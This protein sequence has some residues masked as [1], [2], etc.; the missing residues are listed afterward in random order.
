MGRAPPDPSSGPSRTGGGVTRLDRAAV[1]VFLLAM[2][3]AAIALHAGYGVTFD[4]G[5]QATYGDLA[6]EYYASAGSD[7]RVNHFYN[8]RYYGPAV[9]MLASGV[10]RL[11]PRRPF[12]TRHLVLGLLT[13]LVIPALGA[14]AR[15]LDRPLLPP[16][17]LVAL[18][19]M[20]R[21]AGHAFN[22][23]K[24]MPFAVAFTAFMLFTTSMFIDGT[25]GW[26]R[27]LPAG[28]AF[29]AVLS[30]RPGSLVL[31]AVFFL[32]ISLATRVRIPAAT[33]VDGAPPSG[34][35]KLA[36]LGIAWAT[37]FAT[38]PW[39]HVRPLRGLAEATALAIRFPRPT[40][41]LFEGRIASSDALPWYY[42]PKMLAITTPPVLLA[43]AGLGVWLA[44]RDAR[45][46]HDRGRIAVARITLVWV[47]LPICLFIARRP[48][49]YDGIRHF[50]FLLPGLAILAA[51][52][53]SALAEALRERPGAGAAAAVVVLLFLLPVPAL[54]RLH[55]Y[56]ATYFNALVGGVAGAQERYDTDY[57]MSSY[58]EAVRWLDRRAAGRR[59]GLDVLMGG[60]PVPTPALTREGPLCPGDPPPDGIELITEDFLKT[61]ATYAASP[62]VRIHTLPER[63]VGEHPAAGLDMYLATTR[64]GYDR[65]FPDAPVVHAVARAGA[66][67]AVVKDIAGSIPAGP[68]GG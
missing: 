7:E 5:A 20:P 65:C 50:L 15:R 18:F 40:P 30:I 46:G 29:G 26:R 62:A 38:W 25:Y 1:L 57:W 54:V 45:G 14:Y 27:V 19:T 4:E 9:E 47:G 21:F 28:L 6:I 42:L 41:V 11:T 68:P 49:V 44:L 64:F 55:P 12:Q 35:R 59:G 53:A 37:L 34:I 56:Q 52:G 67:F 48:A 3:A 31:L 16:L 66:T 10:A 33:I 23:S 24:D 36:V 22:N 60:L 17:A 2:A 63:W 8:L 32:A 13:L 39:A 58:G 43:L 51:L 61:V